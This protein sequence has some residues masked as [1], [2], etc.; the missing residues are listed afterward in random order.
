MEI[1][2]LD[3]FMRRRDG[4]SRVTRDETIGTALLAGAMVLEGYAKAAIAN[5]PKTGKV[6]MH[7]KVAHQAS[8]PGEAPAT[9]TGF[10]ANSIQSKRDGAEARV[11][12]HSEY[13]APLE[14]GSSKMAARPYLRP[15]MDE[16]KD[17]I[18]EAV[19]SNFE[20]AIQR[21]MR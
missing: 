20:A 8:A 2:G 13:A 4:L 18:V 21:A 7:G 12:V 1:R 6:Y 15:A 19:A 16:H 9:D 10:L 11:D 14:F 3:Q 5:P 17:A